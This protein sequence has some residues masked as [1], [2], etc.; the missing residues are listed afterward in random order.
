MEKLSVLQDFKTVR[1][2]IRQPRIGNES[3]WAVIVEELRAF[4]KQAREAASM[5]VDAADV[6]EREGI[7]TLPAGR[8]QPG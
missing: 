8:F 5:A 2:F 1:I 7:D 3:E 4:G 6:A